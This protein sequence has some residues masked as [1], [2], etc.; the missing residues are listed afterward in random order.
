MGRKK[1]D[2]IELE[3]MGAEEPFEEEATLADEP[4]DAPQHEHYAGTHEDR[5][6]E[7]AITSA[8]RQRRE[9]EALI[10]DG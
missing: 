6:G 8:G 7:A 10:T 9:G 3:P 2:D 5:D 1:P 4:A